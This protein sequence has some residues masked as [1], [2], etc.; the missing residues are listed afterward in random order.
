MLDEDV[1]KHLGRGTPQVTVGSVTLVVPV[2]NL[3]L[4]LVDGR[5]RPR[6]VRRLV[7]LERCVPVLSEELNHQVVPTAR[8]HTVL[9]VVPLDGPVRSIM[10]TKVRGNSVPNLLQPGLKVVPVHLPG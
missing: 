7:P 2:D 3:F 4:L 5:V 8:L 9:K 10:R 1:P 6:S